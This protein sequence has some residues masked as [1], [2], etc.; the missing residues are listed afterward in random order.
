[1]S[2]GAR[3]LLRELHNNRAQRALACDPWEASVA[4][5]AC[6]PWEAS[7]A[8]PCVRATAGPPQELE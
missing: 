1:M 3:D 5:L 7:V 6:D 8:R 4:D 2:F